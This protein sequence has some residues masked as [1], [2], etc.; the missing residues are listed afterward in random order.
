MSEG[1]LNTLSLT[2]IY[3]YSIQYLQRTF[4]LP[5]IK[6]NALEST[7]TKTNLC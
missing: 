3:R 1:A 4:L 6:F 2:V 7:C 5:Q